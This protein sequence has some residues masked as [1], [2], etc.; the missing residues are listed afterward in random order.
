MTVAERD[1]FN[2]L[3][4]IA[5]NSRRQT[6]ALERIADALERLAGCVKTKEYKG[7]CGRDESP[8]S[9]FYTN[10]GFESDLEGWKFVNTP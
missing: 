7:P 2:N 1:A 3:S 8:V 6:A 5:A 10:D 9:R 4:T